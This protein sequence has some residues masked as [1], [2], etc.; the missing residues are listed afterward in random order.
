MFHTPPYGLPAPISDFHC[1]CGCETTRGN[2]VHA[3]ER[4]KLVSRIFTYDF[5]AAQKGVSEQLVTDTLVK[6][7]LKCAQYF[8]INYVTGVHKHFIGIS[9]GKENKR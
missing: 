7:L 5:S 2:A 1:S 9:L 6:F 8:H 3:Q 4:P